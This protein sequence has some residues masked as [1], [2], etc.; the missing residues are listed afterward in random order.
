MCTPKRTTGARCRLL[1]IAT[2]IQLLDALAAK[3]AAPTPD[4]RVI[5]NREI[6]ASKL[7]RVRLWVG[8][9]H[10]GFRLV[11]GR[12]TGQDYFGPCVDDEV[13]HAALAFVD[14]S[15]TRN[16]WLLLL[17]CRT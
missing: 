4:C 2:L 6:D 10:R 12:V 3:V 14:A 5:S 11:D 17:W 15:T 9:E 16:V 7:A 13:S 8:R 1:D